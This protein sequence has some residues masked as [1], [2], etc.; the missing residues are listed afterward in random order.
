[1]TT[2]R[3][4]QRQFLLQPDPETNQIFLYVLALAAQ[5]SEVDVILPSVQADHHHTVTRDRHGR[6]VEFYEYLHKLTA[7]AM[8]AHR[9]RFENFW[10]S[11]QTSVVELVGVED[12]IDKIVYAATN[13]VKDGLVAKVHHWPGVNGLRA[14]L[15]RRT[16]TVKR[17]RKRERVV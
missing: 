1:M 16:I 11:E 4:T 15:E 14:L 10:A 2:R 17:P 12:I 3:C 13:P 9:G 6:I 8:N 7:R 5:R